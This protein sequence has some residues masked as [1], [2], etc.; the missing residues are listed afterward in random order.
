MKKNQLHCSCQ[1]WS[2]KQKKYE[3]W[4]CI[5][6]H[7]VNL[8]K[9]CNFFYALTTPRAKLNI[10]CSSCIVKNILITFDK[11]GWRVV[12]QLMNGIFQAH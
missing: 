10:F 4:V 1:L 5:V 7:F 11:F 8:E 6:G 3:K 9:N 12:D 2:N